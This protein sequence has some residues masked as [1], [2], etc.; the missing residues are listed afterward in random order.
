MATF[1]GAEMLI[2]MTPKGSARIYLH[3]VADNDGDASQH[4]QA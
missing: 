1:P 2:A 4:S 3:E